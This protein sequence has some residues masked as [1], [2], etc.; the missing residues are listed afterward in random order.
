MPNPPNPGTFCRRNLLG[1]LL[2]AAG[3][4]VFARPAAA[5]ILT[6]EQTAGPFYPTGGMRNADT[7]N[8]LVRIAGTVRQ[9]GGQIVRLGGRVLDRSGQ[10]R[11]G[12]R[13]EIWQCDVNGRYMHP[14][15][16]RHS[17]H[18]P[19]FQGFG[20]DITDAEGR[21]RFRTIRPV[22]Y[23][24]RTPHI[25]VKVFAGRRELT[26]Q[27]YTAGEPANER[28]GIFRRLSPDERTAVLMQFSG[29]GDEPSAE[30]DIVL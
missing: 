13:V 28:D 30:V 20:H 25:H 7:D 27:F 24:G 9:A 3:A 2:G 18:D 16:R 10:P 29:S 4:G 12:A 26:T 19:A 21:Y 14:A 5:A 8:D 11:E 6:P 17:G 22:A 23:P 1:A 15:D